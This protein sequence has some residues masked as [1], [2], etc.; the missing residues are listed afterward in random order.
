[1]FHSMADTIRP[2]LAGHRAKNHVVAI[3]QTDRFSSF[4]LYR[5]TAAYCLDKIEVLGLAG[6]ERI[7]CRADGRTAYGDWLVPR[8]WDAREAVLRTAVCSRSGSTH[9]SNPGSW[10]LT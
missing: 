6:A 7:P 9:A 3:H 4:D 5:Q 1:M 8:A 2:E 10:A